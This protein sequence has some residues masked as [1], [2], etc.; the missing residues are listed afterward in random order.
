[1]LVAERVN[2]YITNLR[3]KPVCDPCLVGKLHLSSAAYAQ[4][5]TAA[6]GTTSDFDR[7]KDTCSLCNNERIAIR[8]QGT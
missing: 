4:Q 2:R 3:G 8:A 5:I 7:Q 1:M 6:L